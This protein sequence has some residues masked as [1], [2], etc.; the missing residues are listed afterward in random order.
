MLDIGLN[1]KGWLENK[2]GKVGIR[3]GGRVVV[4]ECVVARPPSTV[5]FPNGFTFE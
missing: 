1:V 5:S 4:R 3:V 2:K